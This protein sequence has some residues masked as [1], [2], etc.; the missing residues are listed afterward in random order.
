MKHLLQTLILWTTL[1]SAGI[2]DVLVWM[3]SVLLVAGLVSLTVE[4]PGC[5]R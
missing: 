2:R 5:S 3:L 1:Q 4:R